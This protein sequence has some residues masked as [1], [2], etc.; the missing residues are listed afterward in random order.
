MKMLKGVIF[1]LGGLFIMAT[2]M[3]LLMPGHVIISKA[4]P[5]TGDSM[6]IF[7]QL[8][9]LKKWKNWQPVF[10]ADSAQVSYSEITD[11]VNSYA[12]WT[13][14]GKKN[15]LLITEKKYPV[16]KIS[17][18]REGETDVVNILSLMP[19]QEQGNMQV[20]WEAITK[21]GWLPWQRFGG[22]FIERMS[23]P[24]YE[25]ALQSLKEYIESHQ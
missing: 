24:G 6:K 2:I 21:L 10:K 14:N 5:M 7:E 3:G 25:T 15:R 19:V 1:V 4:E 17:L 12:E 9:D 16:V 20:Q 8:S 13:T 18:Q 11:G 22:L 23:G